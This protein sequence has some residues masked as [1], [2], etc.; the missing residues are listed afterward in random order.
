MNIILLVVYWA[1]QGVAGVLFK[2]G[3]TSEA[4]WVPSFVAGNL[5]CA[6]SIWFMMLLYR[7]MN[8]NVALGLGVGGAFLTIQ[9][10]I[11]LVFKSGLS[12]MQYGGLLAITAGMLLLTL[13]G[14]VVP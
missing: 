1:T 14:K 3:S 10:A 12:L 7:T 11:V 8:P 2:F 4:R 9:F 13:G 5:I 6:A